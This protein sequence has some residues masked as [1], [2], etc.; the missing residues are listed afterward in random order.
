MKIP[1]ETLKRRT[2]LFKLIDS[3]CIGLHLLRKNY[4]YLKGVNECWNKSCRIGCSLA[5]APAS[6]RLKKYNT[7]P[8]EQ[9]DAT[10]L[11]FTKMAP[12]WM[13]PAIPPDKQG[14]SHR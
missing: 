2:I 5:E 10:A 9:L 14:R 3:A 11:P 12:S 1:A 13:L 7:L 6:C 4:F 8:V